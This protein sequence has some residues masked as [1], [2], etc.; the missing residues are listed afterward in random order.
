MS[1]IK[2]AL[3][4]SEAVGKTSL[5]NVYTKGENDFKK[6]YEPTI[7]DSAETR[8]TMDGKFLQ[9]NMLDTAGSDEYKQLR[10]MSYSGVDLFIICYSVIDLKSH[11]RVVECIKEVR[12]HAPNKE[13]VLVGT[14][15]DLRDCQYTI[16]RLKMEGNLP[17]Y[18][19]HGDLKAAELSALK[20]FECSSKN[21]SSV[22]KMFDES[23]RLVLEK[24]EKI[25]FQQKIR[26]RSSPHSKIKRSSLFGIS[27]S[28]EDVLDKMNSTLE[29]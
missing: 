9:V 20:Y 27:V 17:L 23:I 1:S 11:D 26:R 2:V 29:L 5:I 22:K 8:I 18:Q 4:G 12:Q 15:I 16:D 19:S 13:M 24:Q 7:Y 21:P 6:Q 28:R 25:D 14:K 3:V 10:P